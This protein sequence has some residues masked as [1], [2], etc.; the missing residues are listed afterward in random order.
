[1]AEA[2]TSMEETVNSIKRVADIIAEISSSS[3]EQSTGISQV[4][5][6]VAQMD[7]VTQQNAALVEEAS[8]ASDSMREQAATLAQL[9]ATFK[10]DLDAIVVVDEERRRALPRARPALS[11]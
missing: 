7:Q 3:H 6:A 1:M 11:A 2:G 4:N 5:E 8:A 9:V 10:I